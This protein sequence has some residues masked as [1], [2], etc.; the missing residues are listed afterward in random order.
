MKTPSVLV[1]SGVVESIVVVHQI[2]RKSF[3]PFG[4][5]FLSYYTKT[6]DLP[7]YRQTSCLC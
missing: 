2:K 4:L 6:G 5:N 3:A 7:K 1:Y